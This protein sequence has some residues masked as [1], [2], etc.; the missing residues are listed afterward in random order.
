MKFK[1]NSIKT[2]KKDKKQPRTT[3]KTQK[4]EYNHIKLENR[5]SRM[6]S[7]L[8]KKI[9]NIIVEHVDG[10]FKNREDNSDLIQTYLESKGKD[11]EEFLNKKYEEN[12]EE[13][14]KMILLHDFLQK[15]SKNLKFFEKLKFYS[16]QKVKETN[17]IFEKLLNEKVYDYFEK[18]FILSN[19]NIIENKEKNEAKKNKRENS[20]STQ[21]N[22]SMSSKTEDYIFF[23]NS[24]KNQKIDDDTDSWNDYLTLSK[25]ESTSEFH[26]INEEKPSQKK[27]REYN[28]ESNN[29]RNNFDIDKPYFI[30]L[31]EE[32]DC[33]QN[34]SNVYLHTM[35]NIISP[36]LGANFGE[37]NC[38]DFMNKNKYNYFE[39]S[40]KTFLN[41]DLKGKSNITKRIISFISMH[42]AN[43]IARVKEKLKFISFNEY[44]FLTKNILDIFKKN[45]VQIEEI[46]ICLRKLAES[47]T[48]DV[49]FLKKILE[50]QEILKERI[51]NMINQF[52]FEGGNYEIALKKNTLYSV[53]DSFI[54]FENNQFI[55]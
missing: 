20:K 53:L 35:N 28:D 45:K 40:F 39:E 13:D 37:M 30:E 21:E 51:N 29:D 17:K 12:R 41:E 26:I 36:I 48:D 49:E 55:K 32:F 18:T 5:I 7:F 11:R 34:K 23:N 2:Q 19:P 31:R 38:I 4:K 44:D 6:R 46:L 52:C 54:I 27:D 22:S 24:I 16:L 50:N 1:S 43:H 14:F 10:F 47:K 25:E 15:E 9:R 42:D 8:N 3:R 33:E